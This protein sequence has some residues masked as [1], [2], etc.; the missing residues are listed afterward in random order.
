M[1]RLF[2]FCY[3]YAFAVILL[4]LALT[5]YSLWHAQNLTVN[6]STESLIPADSP[7][8]LEY[9]RVTDEFGSDQ[10]ALI[11]VEDEKLFTQEKLEQ[12]KN[13]SKQL[14][15]LPQVQRVESLFTVNDIRAVNGWVD[16]SPLLRKIPKTDEKLAQ[17]KQ[18]AIDNP[19]MRR[20]IISEDGKA[21]VITLYLKSPRDIQIEREEAAK[22]QGG[23]AAEPLEKNEYD[24]LVYEGI[25]NILLGRNQA[26]DIEL[27]P[28][29]EKLTP[30]LR[31]RIIAAKKAK[32]I[33]PVDYSTKFDRVFQVGSPALHVLMAQYIFDDMKVMLPLA[34]L[35][36]VILLGAMMRSF[37]AAIIPV[38]NFI[39]STAFTGAAMVH[40][41]IP[42]SMLTYIV[43]ALIL[44]IGATE[45]V[46]ILNEF[47][48]AKA[49]GKT[50]PDLVVFIAQHIG[51][52][53]F[54]TGL[55]TSLGFAVTGISSLAIMQEFGL[56][57]AIAIL[58]RFLV[59]LTFLPA[60][61]RIFGRFIKPMKHPHGNGESP[62]N[63]PSEK[64]INLLREKLIKHPRN[65]IIGFV[66]IALP[67][68]AL[69]PQI[70]VSNDLISFLKPDSDIVQE[71]DLVAEQLS[72][73]KVIYITFYGSEGEFKKHDSLQKLRAFT[74]KL[75][76]DERI[77]TATSVAD[78]ISLV[79]QAMTGG[80]LNNR[81]IPDNDNLIAQYLV[82]FHS[83]DLQPYVA[84]K[85]GTANIV[86]RSNLS[87]SSELNALVEEI[88]Q[89]VNSGEYGRHR[90]S[91]TGK[92]VM[93]A[94][95]VDKIISGQVI[96]LSSMTALLFAIV[97]L[98]FVSSRAATLAVLSNLFPVVV[99]F[100]VMAAF[101]VTLN[102]GTCM[103]AAITIGIAV[104]DTLHMMVRYNKELKRLK[105]EHRAILS[106]VKA[107]L[108]PVITTSL[109]LAGGFIILGFSSFV[110]VMQFGLLSALVMVL[111][112]I[113]DVILTP[114]LLSTTRLIT[115][116]DVLG[117][118]LRKAL[119][120]RSTMFDGLTK[121]QAKKLILLANLEE[122]EI[123][124]FVVR[125][126]E[127]GNSMYV[128]IDGELEV[129]KK[130]DGNKIVLTK[131]TLGDVFG[132]VSLICDIK[133]TASVIASTDAR[134]L[135]LNWSELENLQRYNPFLSSRL[136]LNLSRIL[137]QRLQSS[138]ERIESPAPFPTRTPFKSRSRGQRSG[139]ES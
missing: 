84:N 110:P 3:D 91:I 36:L 14:K 30:A 120:E 28:G 13:L 111:A 98:L 132:E 73:S 33:E 48:E 127:V 80:E 138:N 105:D 59:S 101:G 24:K 11:Y 43:P 49:Q 116:W 115:L 21:T 129:S 136:F 72:G 86:I 26:P 118:N 57:A 15:A 53:L 131:L 45:D 23:A 113:A 62:A 134:L 137:C 35:I 133:R 71:L 66:L 75:S 16:T 83:S 10:L 77:D 128:V 37:Q 123:G 18:Q 1:Q 22:E 8:R 76:A 56:V 17:K 4:I 9:Q 102:V 31:E 109:G 6:V 93:V 106:S 94:S 90:Y 87:D 64:F 81:R 25:Q 96:S 119:L 38:L 69:I 52:T 65:V 130:I 78:Y 135:R 60:W 95:A 104:D 88:R 41:G 63:S 54:L 47:R 107:E 125:E 58:S 42:L 70:R 100:G 82:F 114:V 7:L 68:L 44:I 2:K 29:A 32:I 61:L 74:E 112:L 51:L 55:T 34:C 39:I 124:E 121:W 122:R 46:H 50:G 67:C 117:F 139:S 40:L 103:V 126:G 79:N 85:F 19:L 92:S 27:P 20:A 99:V 108:T 5:G 89:A 12:L 97:G